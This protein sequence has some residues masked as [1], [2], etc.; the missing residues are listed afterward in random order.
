MSTAIKLRC[1][2]RELH[3]ALAAM[4]DVPLMEECGSD[5]RSISHHVR[6]YVLMHDLYMYR[7]VPV[8][9]PNP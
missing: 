3:S 9:A 5:T 7:S 6:T 1:D 8:E 4:K 2:N